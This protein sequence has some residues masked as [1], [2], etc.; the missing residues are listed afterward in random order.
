MYGSKIVFMKV[1]GNTIVCMVRVKLLGLMA[2]VT[3]VSTNTIR[4]MDTV[5]FS[6]LTDENIPAIGRMVNNMEGANTICPT[7][8]RRSANGSKEKR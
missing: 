6:G 4:S 1:N 5:F 3:K 2:D 7:A 8:R